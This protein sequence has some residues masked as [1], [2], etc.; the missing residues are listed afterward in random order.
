MSLIWFQ[1]HP[2]PVEWAAQ[3]GIVRGFEGQA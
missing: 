2:L 3:R 1:R